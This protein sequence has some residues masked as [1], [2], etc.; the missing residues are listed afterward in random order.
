[1]STGKMMTYYMNV[2]R[3][4]LEVAPPPRKYLTSP[5]LLYMGFKFLEG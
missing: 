2:S 1:M 5:Y 4:S 3:I